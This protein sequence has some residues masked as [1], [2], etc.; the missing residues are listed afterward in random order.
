MALTREQKQQITRQLQ[1]R[2]RILRVEGDADG[3]AELEAIARV[4][5]CLRDEDYGHC[6]DCGSDIPYARLRA[7]PTA[8]RCARCQNLFGRNFARLQPGL[9]LESAGDRV[10]AGPASH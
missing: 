10:P 9:P 3:E 7:E 2:E 8:S 1:R 6:L 4:L 5:Q